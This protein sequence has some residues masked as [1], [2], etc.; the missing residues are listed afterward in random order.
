MMFKISY[1]CYFWFV[2]STVVTTWVGN[3][4]PP[5]SWIC[6]GYFDDVQGTNSKGINEGKLHRCWLLEC[7]KKLQMTEGL[8]SSFFTKAFDQLYSTTAPASC[9]RLLLAKG[10][11]HQCLNPPE[12]WNQVISY[13]GHERML[14]WPATKP[15]QER[16]GWVKFCKRVFAAFRKSFVLAA[17]RVYWTWTPHVPPAQTSHLRHMSHLH[18]RLQGYCGASRCHQHDFLESLLHLG[19]LMCLQKWFSS[20]NSCC[21][22]CNSPLEKT[23]WHPSESALEKS[24]LAWTPFF[25]PDKRTLKTHTK[26]SCFFLPLFWS[27]RRAI[28]GTASTHGSRGGCRGLLLSGIFFFVWFI[29]I[30]SWRH[31]HVADGECGVGLSQLDTKAAGLECELL[32]KLWAEIFS[33]QTSAFFVATQ[34]LKCREALLCLKF[35]GK[36]AAKC[37]SPLV[38]T[39][40][41]AL[42]AGGYRFFWEQFVGGLGGHRVAKNQ[43]PAG[44]KIDICWG[45]ASL[46]GKRRLKDTAGCNSKG[47]KGHGI[48]QNHM[49]CWTGSLIKWEDLGKCQPQSRQ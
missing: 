1:Y 14:H 49:L 32:G 20:T 23:S 19:N 16:H 48:I 2:K 24:C 30:R 40:G 13:C 47:T 8:Q 9:P 15:C 22:T 7:A 5:V 41:G 28:P 27:N 10:I 36:N 12:P 43:L 4:V 6:A 42:L 3:R 37:K 44:K 17:F 18:C 45:M 35:C 25:W 31:S 11:C 26:S 39:L 29:R 21:W 34:D 38:S 33:H 46:I